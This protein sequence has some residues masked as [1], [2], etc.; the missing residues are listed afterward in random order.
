MKKL[1]QNMF[2]YIFFFLL[3][4]NLYAQNNTHWWND[5]VFYEI[6][7]RSFYDSNG[8]GIGDIKGVIEKLDYL[9]DGNPHT[10]TDLGVKGI[11]LMPISP[12]PS[13]HGYDV[14]NYTEIHSQYGTLQDFKTLMEECHKRGIRVI[15]D[16]VMNHSSSQHPWFIE[17]ASSVASPYRNWYRWSPTP[18]QNADFWGQSIWHENNNQYYYGIFSKNMPDLNYDTPAVKDAIFDATTFWL[19]EMKVDGFRLDAIKYIY[20]DGNTLEDLQQTFDFFHDFRMHYKGINPEAMS[21]GEAWT[22]TNKVVKYVEN[23]RLDFCF[24]FDLA[25]GIIHAIQNATNSTLINRM[26]TVNQTYPFLQYGT[27]LTNH[28]I[29]RI[30][31]TLGQNNAR[32][33]LAASLLLTLPGIPFIYYGEEVGMVGDKP[34]PNIR[35]PMQWENSVYGGFSSSTPW[36]DLGTNFA[37][38]NVAS[39]QQQ[40]SS[41]W[42]QYQRFIKLRNQH[43]ALR[44]GDWN[45]I[46]SN[47]NNIFAFVRQ[48]DNQ[49]L[50][51]VANLSANDITNYQLSA[52]S[53]I[54]EAGNYV[55]TELTGSGKQGELTV[56]SAGFS[57]HKPLSTLTS[58]SL[59]VFQ[60]STNELPDAQVTIKV[61]MNRAIAE[62]LFNP[63][64]Q[65]IELIGDFYNWNDNPSTLSATHENGIYAITLSNLPIGKSHEFK[66]KIHDGNDEFPNQDMRVFIAQQTEEEVYI[67][68]S[69]KQIEE[70]R[71]KIAVDRTVVRAGETVYLHSTSTGNPSLYRWTANDGLPIQSNSHEYAVV[72]PTPGSYPIELYVEN[73]DNSNH[74][75]TI[76]ILVRDPMISD[77][78]SVSIIGTAVNGAWSLDIPM[79]QNA[80]NASIW[81]LENQV[82]QSGNIKFRANQEWSANWGSNAFPQGRGIQDGSNIPVIGGTYNI[83]FHDGTGDYVFTL[84]TATD[85][86]EQN[87]LK[88]YPVPSADDYIV[89]HT[90]QLIA[91]VTRI[92]IT[93]LAGKIMYSTVVKESDSDGS[94]DIRMLQAGAY[95]VHVINPATRQ[96]GKFIKK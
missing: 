2:V 25:S 57:F 29:N 19:D 62:G 50:L 83:T 32:A 84:V 24:E 67:W 12:S 36:S 15:I 37:T 3:G 11:W 59:Y 91:N 30:Y 17:S 73:N 42:R 28:D 23:D 56:N 52:G 20:E 85:T 90:S 95:L 60:L 40:Q 74:S 8:D 18:L 5:A 69:D 93:D 92:Q 58:R 76:N 26:Q 66:V 54:I 61:N 6:F 78:N 43:V 96:I 41:L 4:S 80:D 89:V 35:R 77:Y 21:V 45:L 1:V 64:N 7:V 14:T 88:I 82:L 33:R 9:N 22:S 16:F 87:S 38:H 53:G 39:M 65:T 47:T 71:A 55:V 31:G 46:D 49:K 81:K 13:Y 70:L 86:I 72:F 27:F 75:T 79:T 63:T 51:V 44:R 34:D 94:V 10:T 48:T 68:Y